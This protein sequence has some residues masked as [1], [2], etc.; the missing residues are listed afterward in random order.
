M[1]PQVVLDVP[2]TVYV[3]LMDGFIFSGGIF[4]WEDFYCADFFQG[5]KHI[6]LIHI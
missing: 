6:F 5:E 2:S 4:S 1:L 3:L